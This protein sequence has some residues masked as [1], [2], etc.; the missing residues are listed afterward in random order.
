[1]KKLSLMAIMALLG[2][3]SAMAVE[4]VIIP[5]WPDGAPTKN[6]LEGEKEV[7]T[8]RKI[9]VVSQP[10]L[11]IY[12]AKHPNGMAILDI[13]GGGYHFVSIENEGEMLIDY[14]TTHGITW[15]VLKYRLPNGHCT[16][17]LEDGQRAMQILRSE[18]K[19]YKF[20]PKCVGVMGWS[21]GGHFAATLSTMYEKPEYRPDFSILIYPVISMTD[22]THG[23]SR[24]NLIGENPSKEQIEKYSLENRVS[25]DT[26]PTFMVLAADDKTVD[27]MNSMVYAE[28][29]L[30]N[31]VPLSFHLY[32][33]G[34]HGF[35]FKDTCP[36]KREWTGELEN[37]LRTL[38]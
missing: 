27:P 15:A 24:K 38:K 7:R 11:W 22:I 19:K 32:P 5:L 37:W 36:M 34:G 25:A 9:E 33:K 2:F 29:L 18:A 35:G 14:M 28:A 16:V 4:P 23:G 12:P 30:R 1:M 31:K 3:A 6:G 8:G 13:P 21:A 17:P 26:P 20:S 10:E